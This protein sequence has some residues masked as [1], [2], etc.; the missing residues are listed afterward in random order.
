MD[1]TREE[2][3]I[4]EVLR[5]P[6]TYGRDPLCLEACMNLLQTYIQIAR[7]AQPDEPA[8]AAYYMLHG[9]AESVECAL[10]WPPGDTISGE[11]W[12]VGTGKHPVG[13][14][15]AIGQALWAWLHRPERRQ[16]DDL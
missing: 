11:I 14:V 12:F 4:R 3:A 5:D 6:S 8:H 2:Q 10:Y 7:A 16:E 1:E 15:E 9:K 13:L